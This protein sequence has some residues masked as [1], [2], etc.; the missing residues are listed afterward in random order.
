MRFREPSSEHN[1]LLKFNKQIELWSGPE[2]SSQL[3]VI[4]SK[5]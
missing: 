4:Q 5:N 3:L 1:Q 2:N